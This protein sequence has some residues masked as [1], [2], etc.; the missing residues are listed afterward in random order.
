MIVALRTPAA[1]SSCR[2]MLI[3]IRRQFGRAQQGVSVASITHAPPLRA[4][5][6]QPTGLDRH[7][8]IRRLAERQQP[9]PQSRGDLGPVDVLAEHE[10]RVRLADEV[11]GCHG[12]AHFASLGSRASLRPGPGSPWRY[13][14]RYPTE[15][16]SR[17]IR[18]KCA[19][20]RSPLGVLGSISAEPG[21]ASTQQRDRPDTESTRLRSCASSG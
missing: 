1:S 3:R 18:M 5:A 13:A 16:P 15:P 4:P 19:A 17:A 2:S 14:G 11:G 9:K 12:V 7:G 21:R 10:Q 6:E 8:R 20:L